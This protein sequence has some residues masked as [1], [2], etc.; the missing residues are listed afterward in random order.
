MKHL[1]PLSPSVTPFATAVASFAASSFFTVVL[2][3]TFAPCQPSFSLVS[4]HSEYTSNSPAFS[5]AVCTASGS[6]FFFSCPATVV[7]NRHASATAHQR[8]ELIAHLREGNRGEVGE[9]QRRGRTSGGRSR[10]SA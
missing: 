10:C 9:T 3:S 8:I 1:A 7:A 4:P 2:P 6:L 5:S